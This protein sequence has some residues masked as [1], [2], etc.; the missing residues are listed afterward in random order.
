[1]PPSDVDIHLAAHSGS[2]CGDDATAK[3]REK[4]DEM[5]SKGDVEGADELREPQTRGHLMRF[6][7]VAVNMIYSPGAVHIKGPRK[8]ATMKIGDIMD[9]Y[10]RDRGHDVGIIEKIGA[11]G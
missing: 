11:K 10:Y 5:R 3:A 2:N 8:K 7:T 6:S 1:M 9:V 4:V